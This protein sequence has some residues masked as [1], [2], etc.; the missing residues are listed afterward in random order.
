M[1]HCMYSTNE[2][3]QF[4]NNNYIETCLK[5]VVYT[6]YCQLHQRM[7]QLYTKTMILIKRICFWSQSYSSSCKTKINYWVVVSAFL[8]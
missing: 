8:R 2:L 1:L 7:K 3:D 5:V 6:M 4:I